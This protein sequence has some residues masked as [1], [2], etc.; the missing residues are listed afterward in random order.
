MS[1]EKSNSVF[2]KLA[3][4]LINLI[5]KI[6]NREVNVPYYQ[7]KYKAIRGAI[8]EIYI[9]HTPVPTKPPVMEIHK[10]FKIQDGHA[11]M[12][13]E[14]EPNAIVW[15]ELNTMLN[16]IK[17]EILR[18]YEGKKWT[19]KYTPLDAWA[20][21]KVKIT[22]PGNS[23]SGWLSDLELLSRELYSEIFPLIKEKIGKNLP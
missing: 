13:D 15:C 6:I 10:F 22:N 8:L 12:L 4:R 3:A 19:E 16:M 18:E 21:G 5:Y 11:V 20:E 9:T 1:E 23:E 2:Y 14:A 17:G 7:Q